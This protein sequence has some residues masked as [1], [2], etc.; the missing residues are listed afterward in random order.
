MGE[1]K[2]PLYNTHVERGAKMV[3]FAGFKMPVVYTSIVTEHNTVRNKVG[4]FDVSHMGELEITGARA[5]EF[6]DYI[7]TNNVDRLEEGQICYTVA[8]NENGKVLDDLLVYKFSD[9]RVLLVVNASNTDKIY[10]HLLKEKWDDVDVANRTADVA[11]IAV[12][13]P[14]SKELLLKI[15]FCS[16]VADRIETLKYYR[17]FAFHKDGKEVIVSRTGYTGELGFEIY[18]PAEFAVDLWNELLAGGAELG[19]EPIGLGARDTLRFEASLCLYGNELDEETSPLEAGLKWLVKLKKGDFLGRDALA[20]EKE[21]GSKKTLTG[22]E[23]Q[24]RQIARHHF[25]VKYEGRVVG[26]VT[27]GTFAPYLK[28]SLAMAY[29]ESGLPADANGYA[30]EI[31]GKDIEAKRI[32]LPFYKS[33]A[34]D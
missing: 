4:L 13:G 11:Q 34:A 10:A 25:K 22:F 24:G 14:L 6:A 3:E 29:V 27:S 23:I 20:R 33:R 32:A 2:T 19:V 15:P 18:L 9:E 5:A 26:E 1:K 7:V 17:F 28:K 16:D 8:C 12:Q 21:E 30:I 31:R